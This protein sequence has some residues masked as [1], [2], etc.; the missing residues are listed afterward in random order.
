MCGTAAVCGCSAG[1]TGICRLV[2][3][4]RC[5]GSGAMGGL[6]RANSSARTS[7]IGCGRANGITNRLASGARGVGNGFAATSVVS[8]SGCSSAIMRYNASFVHRC[9][10]SRSGSC[11]SSATTI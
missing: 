2:G 1:A 3:I 6:V 5:T 4:S 11:A 8:V 10:I 7:A 9:N